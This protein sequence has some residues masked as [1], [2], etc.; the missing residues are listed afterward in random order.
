VAELGNDRVGDKQAIPPEAAVRLRKVMFLFVLVLALSV[1]LTASYVAG[2]TFDRAGQTG[3]IG[4]AAAAVT[5]PLPASP[6][7]ILPNEAKIQEGAP[8]QSVP[9]V[10]PASVEVI[11]APSPAAV[12]KLDAGLTPVAV[13][14]RELEARHDPKPEPKPETKLESKPELKNNGEPS[15]GEPAAGG[16]E[17]PIAGPLA[18]LYLQVAASDKQGAATIAKAVGKA[19]IDVSILPGPDE[20]TF[21]V[22]AGPFSSASDLAKARASLEAGGY[23][24]FARRF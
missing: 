4:T 22:V 10:P 12:A 21:R 13:P 23:R 1:I 11:A 2:R 14:T 7:P 3:N 16:A 24:P 17:N 6:P 20:S 18:G 19:G 5:T 9:P 8:P 15:K